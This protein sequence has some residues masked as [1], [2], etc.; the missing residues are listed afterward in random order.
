MRRVTL[1][2][3][4]LWPYHILPHYPQKLNDFQKEVIE[5]EMFALILS[6]LFV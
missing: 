4:A 5:Q 1:S 6:T 2:S 3:V